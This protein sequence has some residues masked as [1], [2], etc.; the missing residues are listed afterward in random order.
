[1]KGMYFMVAVLFAEGFETIEALTPC[2]ILRRGGVDVRLV[3]T[4]SGKT[5]KSSHGIPVVC[6]ITL[7]QLD[8]GLVDMFILPGGMPGSNNLYADERVR[9]LVR[10]H[11]LEG[12]PTAAIC[13]APYILGQLGLLQGKRATCYPGFE[14]RLTGASVVSASVVRD[15][16]I[17][18]ANGAGA[19][20]DFSLAALEMLTDR[21]LSTKIATAI[22]KA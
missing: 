21:A 9:A 18:T 7:D 16:N 1:M 6:D 2:D 17:L 5:V 3:S 20:L 14:D 8:P 4:G 15:G 22:M 10:S 19:A 13:A 12:K 11:A